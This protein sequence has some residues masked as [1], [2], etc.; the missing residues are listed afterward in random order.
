MKGFFNIKSVIGLMVLL[1]CFS[2]PLSAKEI[3]KLQKLTDSVYAIVGPMGNR[4]ADNYGNNANF[5]FV[6]TNQGV[7][8]VDPGGTYKGAAEIHKLVKS[9]TD[10]P[11]RVVI[12]TGGQDHRWLGNGYFKKTGAK[13]IA[14]KRAVA[15]QKAR[16]QDQFFMLGNLVG[17]KGLE[18]TEAT[19]ADIEFD[20]AYKDSIGSV[21]FEIHHFGQAHTP[22]DSVVWLPEQKILFSGDI[23]YVDRMLGIMPSSNSKSWVSVY[24]KLAKFNADILVPGHGQVTTLEK[25]KADTY[26]YLVF[27]RNLVLDFMNRGGGIEDVGKLDQSRFSYLQNYDTLKGRNAQKVYEELEWE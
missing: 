3:L 7:L 17:E 11:I 4:D 14:N 15:D 9:V 8:L 21:P 24:E 2:G 16:T 19:Y 6:I 26:D 27:L 1:A 25:A 12:N 18:N 10:K 20:T 23:V 22:G 13:I 5:G